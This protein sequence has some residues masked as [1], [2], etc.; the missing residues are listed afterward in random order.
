MGAVKMGQGANFDKTR[1][2]PPMTEGQA[3]WPL[4]LKTQKR[5]TGL[6]LFDPDPD[7]I[8]QRPTW[9]SEEIPFDDGRTLVL[10]DS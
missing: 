6:G 9:S 4:V 5:G 2:L 7:G 1:L 8:D 10:K 3:G